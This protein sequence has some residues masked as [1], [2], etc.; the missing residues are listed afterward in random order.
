MAHS[1]KEK[2]F[3]GQHKD[4]PKPIAAASVLLFRGSEVLLVKRTG[5]AMAGLWSAPGG[6]VDAGE[7][8]IAAASRELLEETGLTACTLEPLTTHLVR[9]NA[10]PD[11]P[12]RTYEIAVFAG[13]AEPLAEPQAAG[14]AA[15]ARFI[16]M[17]DLAA[18][19]TTPGLE[20]LV[21][22]ARRLVANPDAQQP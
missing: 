14:D 19:P 13:A 5:G 10:A 7:T 8:A 21:E 12:E 2:E 11:S 18:L 20:A 6:H 4:G 9:I 17:A 16:S 15:D 1:A 3:R 22:A